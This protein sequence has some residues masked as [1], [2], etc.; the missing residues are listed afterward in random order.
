MQILLTYL[1][2]DFR[3]FTSPWIGQMNWSSDVSVP[4]LTSCGMTVSAAIVL[5]VEGCSLFLP[6]I[7]LVICVYDYESRVTDEH[8]SWMQLVVNEE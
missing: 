6:N 8:C 5:N 3:R 7:S 4:S 1:C 2:C